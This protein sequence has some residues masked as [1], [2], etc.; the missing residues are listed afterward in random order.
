M[1]IWGLHHRW[2]VKLKPRLRGRSGA[3]ARESHLRQCARSVGSHRTQ[4]STEIFETRYDL[5]RL[6]G[7]IGRLE[8]WEEGSGWGEE[9]GGGRLQRRVV[10]NDAGIVVVGV[11]AGRDPAGR[12]GTSCLVSFVSQL[13]LFFTSFFGAEHSSTHDRSRRDTLFCSGGHFFRWFVVWGF[14]CH[15]LWTQV[16]MYCGRRSDGEGEQSVLFTVRGG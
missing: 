15:S 9:V 13:G 14:G 16:I 11:V 12:A 1:S 5:L 2:A 4:E 3:P 7:L 8:G 6:A 10:G